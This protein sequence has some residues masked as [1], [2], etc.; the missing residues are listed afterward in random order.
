MYTVYILSFIVNVFAATAQ[1]DYYK[2][3]IFQDVFGYKPY[4]TVGS[5]TING[6]H[7]P[8]SYSEAR[9]LKTSSNQEIIQP[10]C[11]TVPDTCPD[12]NYRSY[13]GSCNNLRNPIWGTPN[14]PYNRLLPANYEDGI[15]D[16]VLSKTGKELPLARS[17]SLLLYPDVPIEDP[18]FTLNAM[19]YGQ[20]ITHDLS[21]TAGSTQTQHY[22]T[23][24]CSEDGQLLELADMPEH[25]FPMRLPPNDPAHLNDNVKCMSFDR[26]IT[27]R[28]RNCVK[29]NSP[30]EQLTSVNHFLDLSL[31]YGN[32]DETNHQLREFKGGRLRYDTRKGNQ[33]PPRASNASGTCRL[34][35]PKDACYFAGDSRINQNPQLALLHVILLREHNRIADKLSEL[36]PHWDDETTFQEAR[37][38]CIAEHQYITYYEW[39]PYFIGVERAL[40]HGL[41]WKTEGFVNDYNENVDPTVLNEHSTAALRNF[42][43]LI[44]GKLDLVTEERYSQSFMRFTDVLRRPY[45]IESNNTFDDLLRGLTSQP[46]SA[47]DQ[48]HDSEIT[49]FLFREDN[50]TFGIDLRATDIQRN[51][52]HGLG[53]YNDYRQLWKKPRANTFEDLLDTISQENILKLSQLYEHPDDIDLIVGGSLEKNLK[54]ALVGP[55]FLNI[56][57]EQFYRTRVGD[58]F[59]FE[60]NGPL[61]FTLPQ[62][63]EIRKSSISKLLCDNGHHI[64]NMQPRGFEKIS[65]RMVDLTDP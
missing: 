40:A 53:S 46:Q 43:T 14:T 44:A 42:H 52:D 15:Q 3:E 38:I 26:T 36:N 7:F 29:G 56:I 51:R 41:I 1:N 62:L 8:T 61:G 13:D 31:V 5:S 65:P 28:D 64:V 30:A 11:G 6:N 59:W 47:S 27:N 55:T 25:C 12:T 32:D 39:L 2:S 48:F 58:R 33:W 20:I 4:K 54:D 19:Q 17:V 57:I 21:M 16:P 37:K 10:G 24:C 63:Q 35:K 50:E 34:N 49:Q 60:N 45:V 18:I 23:R 9:F 22:K